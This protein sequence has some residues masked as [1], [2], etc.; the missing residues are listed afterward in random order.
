MTVNSV[1]EIISKA[2]KAGKDAEARDAASRG[3]ILRVRSSGSWQWTLRRSFQGRDIRVDFRP[4][5]TR[6]NEK[7]PLR[8]DPCFEPALADFSGGRRSDRHGIVER[9]PP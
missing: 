3:L 7:F 1:K 2:K 8:I 6:A 5:L 4:E 9:Y